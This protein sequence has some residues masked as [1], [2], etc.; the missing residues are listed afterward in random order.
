M[1][2]PVAIALMCLIA[3]AVN[4][5]AAQPAP[6]PAAR[7]L[8]WPREIRQGDTVLRYYQPQ[9]DEWQDRKTLKARMAVVLS[10]PAFKQPLAGAL[11]LKADT[12]VNLDTREVVLNDIVTERVAFS[13]LDKQVADSAEAAVRAIVPKG[14]VVTSLDRVL[15]GL[16]STQEEKRAVPLKQDPP[17]IYVSQTPARLV[18]FDG[19][20]AFSP[21]AGTNLQYAVNTNWVLVN[22]MA[23]A[24]YYLLDD[25]TW[26][27]ASALTGPW[28]RAATI[29]GDLGKLPGDDNWK[30]VRQAV[31]A[32]LQSQPSAAK[33][34]RVIVSSEPAELIVTQGKP[35]LAAAGPNTGKLQVATNT[36]A[37]LFFDGGDQRWYYLVAGRWFRAASLDGPWSFANDDLPPAFKNLPAEGKKARALF[38][39]PGTPQ[40]QEAVLVASIPQTATVSRKE[41]QAQVVYQGEPSFQ[42]IPGTAG[43]AYAVNAQ[44]AVIRFGPTAYYVVDRGVWFTAPAPTGPW[45][46]ATSVP[47]EL[48]AIPPA[49]PVYN[50]TYV[51]VESASDDEVVSSFTAGYLGGF[52]TAGLLYW[53]TGY[54]YPPYWGGGAYWPRP[55]T[56]GAAAWYNPATN[57]YFRGG[58]VYGPYGGFGA[59]AA[60]NAATGTY[61]RGVAAYGPYGGYKA[62]V[63]YNPS[64]GAWARGA[65]GYG[66]NG[67]FRAG[68]GYNP[69]TGVGAAGFQGSNV[70]GSWGRGVVTKGDQ[71][72][73]GAYRTNAAGGAAAGVRTSE[74]TG[75]AGYRT[76]GGQTGGVVKGQNNTYVGHDGNVYRK[77]D[78][79]WQKYDNGSWVDPQR[80]AP[81]VARGG[82]SDN[83]GATLQG[84]TAAAGAQQLDRQQVQQRQATRPS[85][86]SP[87]YDQF[88]RQSL[89]RDGVSRQMGAQR[90]MQFQRQFQGG[91]FGGGAGMGGRRRVPRPPLG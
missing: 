79:G 65:A 5:A 55:Y 46:V 29:P 18:I 42:P 72:A 7:Q 23:S 68:A 87:G 86:G 47:P 91:G 83:L 20:P 66:P 90:E 84:R 33:P 69:S 1:F 16:Q 58:A 57:T 17:R 11:W 81:Q 49:A 53:G 76:A 67:A 44:P 31:E 71:W 14:P 56:Y 36:D 4:A 39:V 30:D 62:G 12:A 26:L 73:Q 28:K 34:S 37:D 21:I 78:S 63:A 43:L 10:G 85:G 19:E 51:T 74:G 6:M 54:Y 41:A 59:G 32:F 60:Y 40:A 70:Y 61:V 75:A 38:S 27:T 52:V 15:A 25:K 64:T 8:G 89:D 82:G 88:D 2:R 80:P 50:Y 13:V 3:L 77:T 9:I 24:D 22:E 48:Y 35:V 45:T